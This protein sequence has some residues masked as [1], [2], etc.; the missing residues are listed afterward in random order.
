MTRAT[1]RIAIDGIA[2]HNQRMWDRLSAAG[3]PYTRPQGT[4][5]KT[6]RAKRRLLAPHGRL[7]GRPI[8]GHRAL[9]LAG[10]RAWHPVLLPPRRAP[11]P[12]VD[13]RARQLQ[14]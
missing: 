2:A 12:G 9:A 14:T 1:K 3:I 4:P 10:G 7:A 13:I 6:D 11:A 5:P 8:T